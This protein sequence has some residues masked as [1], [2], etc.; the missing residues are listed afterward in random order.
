MQCDWDYPICDEWV[1]TLDQAVGQAGAS[2][3][4]V[5][6]SLGCLTVAHWAARSDRLCFAVLLVAVPDPSGPAFPRAA[7]GSDFE[8]CL[9][10]YAI[11]E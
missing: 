6:H 3:I 7:I 9:W 11:I 10:R 2:P 4:L 1:E 5:A 8:R